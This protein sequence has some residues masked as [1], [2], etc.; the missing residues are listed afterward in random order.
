MGRS[1]KDLVVWQ[2]AMDLVTST[3]RAT[4]RFPKDELFGLTSQA[5][6][7]A[8]SIP[9]NIAEG[10]GRLSE[11]EFRHFLGLA[12]GSLMELEMQLQVSENLGY[13]PKEEVAG[14]LQSCGE[15]GRVL[16][17]LIASI[18]KQSGP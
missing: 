5:R 3:H 9:S 15:V 7:A 17:G 11:N 10:Q 4:A 2:K 13:L 6:R 1:Y 8:V 16:N 12:R 18:A 14:L